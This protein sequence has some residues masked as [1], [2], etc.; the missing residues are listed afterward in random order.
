MV[1]VMHVTN[2]EGLIGI[3]NG[4]TLF[5]VCLNLTEAVDSGKDHILFLH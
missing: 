1:S 3:D 5:P 2:F 4:P